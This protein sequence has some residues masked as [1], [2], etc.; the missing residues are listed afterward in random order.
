MDYSY[1][2]LKKK[3]KKFKKLSEVIGDNEIAAYWQQRTSKIAGFIIITL[4]P[5]LARLNPSHMS[6][7]IIIFI[8]SCNK[9]QVAQMKYRPPDCSESRSVHCASSGPCSKPGTLLQ[10]GTVNGRLLLA[11]DADSASP[12]PQH[13]SLLFC[14]EM[15]PIADCIC[16]QFWQLAK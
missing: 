4:L 14:C 6:Q 10:P 9:R 7:I 3:K 5:A 8:P 11:R 2:L 15:S 1:W 16:L 12:V 13:L